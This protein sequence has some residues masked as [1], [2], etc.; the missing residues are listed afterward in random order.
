MDV[1][2]QKQNNSISANSFT[3]NEVTAPKPVIFIS[4]LAGC[5]NLT[6]TTGK[7]ISDRK[8]N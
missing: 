2:L 6:S 1:Q 8:H 3:K 5:F 7:S 4:N